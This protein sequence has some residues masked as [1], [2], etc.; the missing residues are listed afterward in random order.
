MI[1]RIGLVAVAVLAGDFASSMILP[2]LG[3][4]DE[5]SA[6]LD[7]YDIA[8]ALVLGVVYVLLHRRVMP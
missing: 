6:S 7:A 4:Y 8:N 5:P 1:R 2:K 3:V